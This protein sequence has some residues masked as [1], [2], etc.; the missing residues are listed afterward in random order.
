MHPEKKANSASYTEGLLLSRILVNLVLIVSRDLRF[1]NFDFCT[2][3]VFYW[4]SPQE[5]RLLMTYWCECVC[6]VVQLCPILC[7]RID[8][9]P[10]DS[11]VPGMSQAGILEWDV[12]SSSRGSSWPRGGARVS[13]SPALAGRFFTTEP[14]GNPRK[15]S[16][17]PDLNDDLY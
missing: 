14:P 10:P 9:S 5:H 4:I 1:F 17:S 15:E 2:L 11:T 12:I 7:D 13:A 8:C 3:P 6:S 16:C